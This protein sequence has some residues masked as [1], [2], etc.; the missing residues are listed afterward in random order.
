[1]GSSRLLSLLDRSQG[2]L[3]HRP[4]GGLAGKNR[5]KSGLFLPYYCILLS[6]SVL[7]VELHCKYSNVNRDS[8][9]D[10]V[11]LRLSPR[12]SQT[13]TDAVSARLRIRC[14][15]Q[16]FRAGLLEWPKKKLLNN[17][18]EVYQRDMSQLAKDF[19]MRCSCLAAICSS[20]I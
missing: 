19:E 11:G 12:K 8:Q 3:L 17:G 9:C 16:V 20:R 4:V 5:R 13:L 10:R 18:L 14:H 6:P 7:S 2:K 15:R 1:M